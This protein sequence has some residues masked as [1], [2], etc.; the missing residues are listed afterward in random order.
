M[1]PRR[2]ILILA[3]VCHPDQGSEPGLGWNWAVRIADHHDV[4]VITSD[5][6]GSRSAIQTRLK[7]DPALASRMRFVFLPWFK[8]PTS[9]VA[10]WLW[11]YYQPMYYTAYEKW[12]REAYAVAKEMVGNEPGFDLCHQ[13]NMIGFREPGY[14][15][16]LPLPFVWGPVGGTQ[17]VPWGML[18]SLGPTEA[19]RHLC[20]NVINECQKR[21]SVRLRAALTRA[22]AVIAVASDTADTLRRLHGVES[23]VIAAAFGIAN[24]ERGRVRRPVAPLRFVYT[25][26]HL[27]RKG[28]PFALQALA[29]IDTSTPWTFDIVGAGVMTPSWQRMAKRLGIADRVVFHGFVT[30][31]RLFDLLDRGDVYVFP[32]LLEG[33]PASIVEA[34]SLGLPV[35]TTKHQGMQDMV[36]AD[37]GILVEPSRP[38]RLVAGLANAFSALLADPMLVTRLSEGALRRA[39]ELSAA[40]QIPSVM[41]VY[42]RVWETAGGPLHG[43]G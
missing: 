5:F 23:E 12:M 16:R 42:D 26:Q 7:G 43:A 37:C 34:L 6:E 28:V 40:R 9:G 2:K 29:R 35:I 11:N 36:T 18:M 15:W 27:S 22:R 3:A 32:S 39:D 20:R 17:N 41:E 10:A 25:G 31:D 19:I 4:T 13:L 24:H 8:A 38:N 14:L 1:T 30:R 33:W 21:W